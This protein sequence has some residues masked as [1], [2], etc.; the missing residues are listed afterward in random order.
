MASSSPCDCSAGR[1]PAPGARLTRR[2]PPSW[3][4][5]TR[6]QQATLPSTPRTAST[7]SS[8]SNDTK[9]LEDE[10]NA[11]ELGPSGVEIS[12]LSE[13]EL[14]FAVVSTPA[15]LQHRRQTPDHG[16]RRVEVFPGIDR[17]VRRGADAEA[18]ERVL[19][20]Q[21]VLGDLE[22]PCPRAHDVLARE[23]AA[24]DDA[25]TPSHS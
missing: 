14:A 20:G 8:R 9:R 1:G 6:G 18:P 24:S 7:D 17:R 12:R 10:R 5:S 22:R 15:G 11:T 13:H 19:L 3:T 25:G 16:D 23:E 21:P 2:I 4:F